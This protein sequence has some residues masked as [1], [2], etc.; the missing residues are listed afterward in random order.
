MS[1][2]F[3]VRVQIFGRVQGV[4][5]RAW[6]EREAQSR[7]LDGWVR[8][9]QDGTVEAVFSGAE[10]DVKDMIEACWSGPPAAR[11]EE[12]VESDAEHEGSG[13]KVLATA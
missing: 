12:I 11:V 5:Y 10:A 9:R 13:F 4:W 8:N 3:S 2:G 1:D 6:T 7:G